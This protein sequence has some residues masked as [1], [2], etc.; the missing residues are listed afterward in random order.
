MLPQGGFAAQRLVRL[1]GCRAATFAQLP[2]LPPTLQAWQSAHALVP[3]QTPSTQKLP[4]QAVGWSPAH[5][6]PRRFLLPQR[7]VC[8]SQMLGGRQS[9]SPVQAAWQA[10]AP[11]QT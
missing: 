5:G 1:G 8:G 9:A 2:A 11:L 6:W 4:G 10:V 3:Q 7:L